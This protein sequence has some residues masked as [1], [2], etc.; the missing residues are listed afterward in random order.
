VRFLER[1]FN[2]V[3]LS[4]QFFKMQPAALV[5]PWIDVASP[6]KALATGRLQGFDA[7]LLGLLDA[8]L[9]MCTTLTTAIT[10]LKEIVAKVPDIDA[11]TEAC[12]KVLEQ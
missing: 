10:K 5:H 2:A 7:V 12:Y 9:T 1:F 3:L 6:I 8:N 4:D 11:R